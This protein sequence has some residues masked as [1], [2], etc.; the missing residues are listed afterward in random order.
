MD[1]N[2]KLK[3][4]K[5]GSAL[6]YFFIACLICLGALIGIAAMLSIFRGTSEGSNSS[7]KEI[8]ISG[9]WKIM[10]GDATEFS[11][12][13]FDDSGWEIVSLPA[14]TADSA[15]NPDAIQW[16]RKHVFIPLNDHGS[17]NAISLGTIHAADEV[18][19]NLEPSMRRMKYI[20][21]VC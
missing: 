5:K 7:A 4:I 17:Y 18:Y 20:L 3:A 2:G 1:T 6:R 15:G 12:V 8:P 16:L 19:F 13:V 21:T 10:Y 9:E 11:E 14:N